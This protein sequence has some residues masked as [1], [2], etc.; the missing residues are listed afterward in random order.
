MKWIRH[1]GTPDGWATAL[2]A[3][4]LDS[5]DDAAAVPERSVSIGLFDQSVSSVPCAGAAGRLW[6]E[7]S[8]Q[9]SREFVRNL[10]HARSF[11]ELA[12]EVSAYAR[13]GLRMGGEVDEFVSHPAVHAVHA[14]VRRVRLELHRLKGLLRFRAL[15]NGWL[16]G[17]YDSDADVLWPLAAHFSRRMP[18]DGWVLHDVGRRRAIAWNRAEL[19]EISPPAAPGARGDEYAELWKTFFHSISVPGR[20]N[21]EL[22]RRNMPQRYWNWLVE[23]E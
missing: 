23:M 8:A 14:A 12:A 17:P 3:A 2:R 19:R 15:G 10:W 9:V 13:L 4:A 5:A 18:D 7:W 1:D 11:P 6:K 22:Q 16:W 21:P 20:E